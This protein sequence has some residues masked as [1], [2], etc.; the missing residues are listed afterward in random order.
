MIVNLSTLV[1]FCIVAIW[2]L[3]IAAGVAALLQPAARCFKPSPNSR[4]AKTPNRTARTRF[5]PALAL[6]G[7]QRGFGTSAKISFSFMSLYSN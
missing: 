4:S 1:A 7:A 5:A 6:S 2:T 3:V